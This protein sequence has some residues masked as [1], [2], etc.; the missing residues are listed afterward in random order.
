MWQSALSRPRRET[1]SVTHRW[2]LLSVWFNCICVSLYGSLTVN[3]T[4]LLFFARLALEKGYPWT[5]VQPPPLRRFHVYFVCSP[6]LL[7]CYLMGKRIP[8]ESVKRLCFRFVLC[9]FQE[10]LVCRVQRELSREVF[11]K[12][13]LWMIIVFIFVLIIAVILIALAVCAGR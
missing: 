4:C 11:L 2:T 3:L 7:I 13:Q 12:V 5:L 10:S 6:S 9:C 8:V 1:G